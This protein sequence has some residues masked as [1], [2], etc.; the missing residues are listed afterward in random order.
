MSESLPPQS[1]PSSVI[2]WWRSVIAYLGG[3]FL[4][5]VLLV[6]AWSKALDPSAFERQISQEGLDFLL[7]ATLV[8]LVALALEVGL[9]SALLLGV[10]RWFVL[11]PSFGLVVFFLFL[12]GRGYWNY[13]QGIEPEEAG[14]GC[15]GNLV[16]RTPAEAFWQDAL[17]MVP[18]L[19][20]AFLAVQRNSALPH[21]RLAL[22]G[23]LTIGAM[24]FSWQAPNLPLDNLATRLRPGA[25][26][27][28]MCAGS[29]E[30][31]SRVC[32]DGI[33]PEIVEGEH[34]VILTDLTDVAFVE[35]VGALNEYHLSGAEPPLWVV[36][37]SSEEELFQF[38]FG[39]GP[40][41]EVRE[42]PPVLLQ[43]LYRTL[44]R[45]FRIREG[46]V[47]ETWSGLPP[48]EGT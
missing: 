28:A 36:T 38:R 45:S 31:G 44:P 4:G 14:C 46:K 32:L 40:A 37:G 22:V 18:A 42:A 12:T 15:F 29:V 5:A 8:A 47:V 25:D 34:L 1:A 41:F 21:L 11:W 43:P 39:Y 23:L 24:L 13:L 33:L 26:P 3:A 20:L 7:S 35:G 2:P 48:L 17:L 27:G 19:L 9:G 10:R 30:D 16:Q 6:A